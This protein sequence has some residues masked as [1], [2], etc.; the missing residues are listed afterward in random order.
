MP[1]ARWTNLGDMLAWNGVDGTFSYASD[2]ALAN[3]IYPSVSGSPKLVVS[4]SC[5]ANSL[6]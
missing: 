6:R 2:A 5:E 3:L 4:T 1:V